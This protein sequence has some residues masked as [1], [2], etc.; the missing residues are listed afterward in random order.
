MDTDR[1][2]STILERY[3]DRDTVK[4]DYGSATVRKV[5]RGWDDSGADTIMAEFDDPIL[6]GYRVVLIEDTINRDFDDHEDL[7][8]PDRVTT[9]VV[10]YPRVILPEFNTHRVFSRNS[11]SSRARS[12]K[13]TLRPVMEDPY[14]PLW[15]NNQRGMGGAF[16]SVSSARGAVTGWIHA[17][18]SAVRS[19][20]DLL[21]GGIRPDL[22]IMENWESIVDAYSVV[23]KNGD[24]PEAWPNIHKQDVN[25]LIEPWMWHETLVTSAYWKNFLDLRISDQ[26]MPEIHALAVLVRSVL[27]A[28]RQQG[29]LHHATIHVPFIPVEGHTERWDDLK[30]VLLES[31][32]ECARI[33]YHDRDTMKNKD[34]GLGEKL[35]AEKHMSPF[36]HIAWAGRKD[37]WEKVPALS[38]VMAGLGDRD[39]SSN[40]GPGWVQFRRAVSPREQ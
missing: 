8:T 39:L 3:A 40:L 15:T 10:R 13:T 14:I 5:K 4:P 12:I 23:Y 29:T 36:E 33:S 38:E 30:H 1:Q 32:S 27:N 21:I 34:I 2:I 18:D 7:I 11:A 31:A 6:H 26:A 35:L 22:D 19:M 28:S 20:F 24:I 16:S 37:D 17:R 9:L 25:R